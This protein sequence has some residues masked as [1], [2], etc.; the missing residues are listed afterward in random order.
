M[1]L[2]ERKSDVQN[3]RHSNV[4][5]IIQKLLIPLAL[6]VCQQEQMKDFEFD[7]MLVDR[8]CIQRSFED[9]YLHFSACLVWATKATYNFIFGLPSIIFWRH[10]STATR[11]CSQSPFCHGLLAAIFFISVFKFLYTS[12][13]SWLATWSLFSVWN[14]NEPLNPDPIHV[15][16]AFSM[17]FEGFLL[18]MT[19]NIVNCV[20]ASIRWRVHF[21]CPHYLRSITRHS[22]NFVVRGRQTTGQLH[23][24]L[25]LQHMEQVAA[26]S[27]IT[28]QHVGLRAPAARGSPFRQFVEGCAN[29]LWSFV[30]ILTIS[31]SALL[32]VKQFL[33]WTD[34]SFKGTQ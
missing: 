13:H 20:A 32:I 3:A 31:S 5:K 4:D 26:S 27:S 21:P 11:L 14:F 30:I 25:N 23:V 28:L 12:L 6:A 15:S 10:S 33:I 24:F 9:N 34:I 22:L 18:L 7:Q 2:L 17:T 19:V 16:L 29:C 8:N 1:I